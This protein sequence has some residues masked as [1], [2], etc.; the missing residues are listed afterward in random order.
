MGDSGSMVLG[1]GLASLALASSWTVAGTTFATVLLPLLVLAIPIL[2]TTLVTLVRLAQRRPVT[3]G[4]KDHTSHRLVYYGL[5]ESKAVL[6]LA[7]VATDARG[8]RPRLQRPRQ[9]AAD[10]DRDPRHLRPPRAVRELPERPRGAVAVGCGRTA[11]AV[12]LARARLRAAAPR[13][14]R[15]RLRPHLRLVP[16]LV[17]ARHRRTRA[18]SSSARSSSRRCRSC[19]RRGTRSSSGSACTGASGAT[20]PPATSSRSRSPAS[21]SALIAYLIL[22]SL[23]DIG[24]FPAEVFVVDALLATLLVGASRL[25]LRLLPEARA[26]RHGRRVLVVG[27]GRAGRG[28]ARELHDTHEAR[29]VG[30]PRRQPARSTATH[31]R[32]HGGRRVS[33]KRPVPSARPG[34]TR[35]S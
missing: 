24:A 1:F 9:R 34:W 21:A 6:L 26:R 35:C 2:D 7:V 12:T 10:G 17:P 11:R 22:I 14:G 25:T 28:L 32:D 3:Q 27:A 33:T 8:D 29:V 20:R 15:R 13:R 30:L 16:R 4:G 5:S 31:P 19:S 23:R 18:P